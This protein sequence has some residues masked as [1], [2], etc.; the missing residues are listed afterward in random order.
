[1]LLEIDLEKSFSTLLVTAMT[2]ETKFGDDKICL[3]NKHIYFN[4]MFLAPKKGISCHI[5]IYIGSF[6]K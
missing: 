2:T 1:M 4:Y 3:K 6:I 5:Y